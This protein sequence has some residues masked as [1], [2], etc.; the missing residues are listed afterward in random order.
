MNPVKTYTTRELLIVVAVMQIRAGLLM[1]E[2]LTLWGMKK[3]MTALK[4]KLK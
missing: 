4:E 3:P 1:I 2:R